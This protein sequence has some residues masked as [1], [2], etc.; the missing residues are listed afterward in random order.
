MAEGVPLLSLLQSSEVRANPI[1]E[2][3]FF[4]SI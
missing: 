1:L 4:L 3:T 2:S